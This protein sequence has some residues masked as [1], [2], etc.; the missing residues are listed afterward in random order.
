MAFNSTIAL[1][2]K[3]FLNRSVL[4]LYIDTLL[5]A[6]IF[7]SQLVLNIPYM[8]INIIKG[9]DWNYIIICNRRPTNIKFAQIL[10][11]NSTT[12]FVNFHPSSSTMA[13]C[14]QRNKYE[15][16]DPIM[17]RGRMGMVIHLFFTMLK[18]SRNRWLFPLIREMKIR[19][20]IKKKLTKL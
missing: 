19:R 1:G 9:D 8:E 5:I 20:R 11:L 12:N 14:K 16:V 10:L 2:K 7:C 13:N 15:I 4:H 17:S 18:E 3:L 6:Y